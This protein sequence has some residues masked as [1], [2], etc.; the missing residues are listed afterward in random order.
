[1]K[2]PVR[3]STKSV[4]RK[5]WE[6]VPRV[7]SAVFAEARR[8]EHNLAPSHFRILRILSQGGSTPSAL[9][10]AMDVSLPSMSASLQ[11]LV[12]R[13]WVLRQR[14]TQDRR[15]IELQVSERGRQ[16]L[17]E[18]HDRVTAWTARLLEP[19]TTDELRKVEEGIE[20]FNKLFDDV[21]AAPTPKSKHKPR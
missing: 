21:A 20:A 15:S 7:I 12:E 11:T 16:V 10:K 19:L 17:A 5:F 1:M 3:T 4:A 14:S 8:G 6:L 18:E 13:G 2:P 9:A